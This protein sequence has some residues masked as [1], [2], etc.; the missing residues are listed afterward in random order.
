MGKLLERIIANRLTFS[1]ES[2]GL[3]APSQ[4]GFRRGR[5]TEDALWQLVTAASSALQTRQRLVLISLDIQGTYDTVWH[6]GLFQKL[7]HM[8]ISL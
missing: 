2:R 8:G 1:L 7:A 5:G 4:F 6:T 3:L